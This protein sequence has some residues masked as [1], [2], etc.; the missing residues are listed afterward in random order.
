M[1][2]RSNL[3]SH[4]RSA[5]ENYIIREEEEVKNLGFDWESHPDRQIEFDDITAADIHHA[6]RYLTLK[7]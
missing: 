5:A 1:S 2:C 7:V 3:S 6:L 4:L